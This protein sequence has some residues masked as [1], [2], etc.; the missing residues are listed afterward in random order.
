[1]EG[2]EDFQVSIANPGTTTGS[3]IVA[4]GP[5]IVVTTITDND[6]AEWTITGDANVPEGDVA[7]YAVSFNGTLQSGETATI[8][9]GIGD[10]DTN[11]ADYTNFIAA[12]NIAIVSRPEFSFDG[13]TLTYTGDGSPM[14][15]LLIDFGTV[16]DVIVEGPEDYTISIFNPGSTSGANIGVGGSV[17]VTTTIIDNDSVLWSIIGDPSVGEGNDAQYTILLGGRLQSGETATIDL[18]LADVDTNSAD[19][20]NFAAAVNAAVAV[21]SDLSFDGT[22]LTF[23]STGASMSN[24]VVDLTAIDDVLIE[25]VED[26]TVSISNSGSTTGSMVGIGGP[27]S[28]TTSIIDNDS[29]TWSLTGDPTV[30]EGASAGYTLSL[31]GILQFGETATIDLGISEVTTS[32]SD[33]TSFVAAINAAIAGRADLSFDGTTLTYVGDGMGPMTDLV[34]YLGAIDDSLV[35][36]SEDWQI[37]ISNPGSTTGSDIQTTTATSV[38]TTVIDNDVA[39][40]SIS[41]DAAVAEGAEAKYV[42]NLA[43]TL[44][45]GE[46]ATIDLNIGNVSAIAA[47][48]GNFVGSVNDA[49]ANYTGPGTLTFD[50]T[51]LTFTS[52]GNPMDDLCIEVEA[53]D[54][55]LVEG[56]EDFQVSIANPGTTTGSSIVSAIPTIVVTTI[57]DN[58]AAAWSLTGDMTV[59]EGASANYRIALS[60]TLQTGE[61]A[62]IDLTFADIDT[63]PG[64]YNNWIAT[65]NAAVAGRSDLAFDGTTLTY[66]GTGNPMIDLIISLPTVDDVLTESTEQYSISAGNAGSTTG[67]TVTGSGLATTSITDNDS[68]LW[69][70]VGSASVDEGGTAQYK[71][72]LGGVIQAGEMASIELSIQGLEATSADYS[73]FLVAVQTA[74]AGRSDLSFDP[75]TGVLTVTGTGS[76]MADICVDLSAIDDSLIEGPERFQILLSNP[77][78]AGGLSTGVD[79]I[80]SLVTTTINDTIGDGGPIEEAVWSLGVDQT[81][82][83][84]NA[85]SYVLSLS[86]VLQASET[87]TVD[88]GLTDL[89]TT[90]TDY[91][92][93]NAAVASAVAAYVGPGSVSWDGTTFAFTSDGTGAMSPLNISLGTSNDA[94]AEGT[95]DFLIS[96]DNANSMTGASTSIDAA[97]DDAVTT[98]DDTLGSGSDDAT[99]SLIGDI[100]VDEGGIASYTVSLGGALGAGEVASVEIGLGDLDTSSADYASFVAAVNFA[101]NGYNT[102]SGPGSLNWDGTTL[103][104]TAAAD[105]DVFGGITIDFAAVDDLFLEGPERYEVTLSNPGSTTG[106]SAAVDPV[107]NVVVT[108]IND[109]VGDGG[110]PEVGGQWYLTGS[111]A[112]GE[113]NT[114]SYTVGLTGNLQAG[115]VAS[116]QFALGDIETLPGDY[117][118]FGTAVANAVAA[119]NTD[120]TSTGSLAWDGLNLT[121]TSDGR[122][123]M[124]G[125]DIDLATVQDAVVEGDER[126]NLI[127]SNAG[128]TTGLSPTVSPTQ[129][130]VTTTIIDDDMADWSIVGDA[131]VSEGGTAQYT[132]M[133][134]GILQLGETS[135]IDLGVMDVDT[136]STDYASFVSA[137]NTAIAGRPDLSFDG[138]TLTYTADGNPMADL[139]IDLAAVDDTLVESDEDYVVSI[140]NPASTT[141][142]SI[143]VG[144]STSVTTTI[145]DND[146]ATWS[147]SGATNVTEGSPAQYTV[148]LAGE[149]QAGETSTIDLGLANV[150][151]TSADYANFVSSVQ[152]AIVGRSD[153]TFDGT[154]LTYT[155]NGSPMVPLTFSVDAIDDSVVEASEDFKISISNPGSTT[156]ASSLVGGS[157]E[158]T[159][160]I[161]D[162]DDAA[163]S[164][165]GSASVGEGAFAQYTVALS[166]TLQAGESATIDLGLQNLDTNSNDYANFIAAVNAAV[167]GRSDLSFDGT[168]LTYTGDGTPMAD[169][170]IDLEA[171]DDVLTEST[172]MFRVSISNPGSPT[173]S[174]VILGG[175]SSVVT[176]IVDNDVPTWSLTGDATT[177]E[178]GSAQYTL[179]LDGAL[180]L[181]QSVSVQINL[182]DIDTN[183]SDYGDLVAAINAAIVTV[184]GAVFD[185][186]T[187]TIT[188]TAITNGPMPDI[189]FDLPIESD[190]VSEPPED[191]SIGLSNPSSSSGVAPLIDAA[192]NSV[193]T[194]INGSPVLQPDSEYTNADTPFNGNVLDNDSDP[195]G[196]TL[197]VTHVDGQ[198]IGTPIVTDCG[199]V[200]MNADGS[201][202]FTPNPGFYGIDIFT[203]TVVDSAGNEE[204]TTV[205]IEVL[206]AEIGIA[207][208]ASDPVPNG[209]DW[210][211]TFTLAVQNLGNATMTNLFLLDDVESIFGNAFVTTGAPSIQNWAG[212][213]AAPTINAS[214]PG[215]TSQNILSGGSLASGESF[216]VVFTVT[217]DP[218]ANGVSQGLSN[219]AEVSGQGVN[220]DGTPM[221]G[222]NGAPL[223]V[224]DLSD[225]GTDPGGENGSDN[226]DGIPNNDVTQILIADLGIA[227]SIVG[228]PELLFSGNYVV[229]YQVLVENT[230][231]VALSNLSLLEDL[232]TQF[233]GAFVQASGLTLVA[234]PSNVA[235]SIV[236]DSN[237]DGNQNI[238]MINGSQAS[239]LALGDS[240]AIQFSVEVDPLAASGTIG[241]QI[242]GS[243]EAVDANGD[244]LLD[245][246]GNSLSAFDLS[247][248][249]SE[250]GSTN[251]G[252]PYDGGTSQDVTGFDPP[253][254]PL[255]EISG[256]V[257]LDDNNNGIFE[258]GES[259]IEGVEITLLGTDTYG[260]PV[261]VVVFTDASGRYAF[262]G[263]NAGNYRVVETQPP[264][265]SDGIDNGESQWTIGNDEFSGIVLNWGQTFA[266][267]SFGERQSGTGGFPPTFQ[268]LPPLVASPISSLLNGYLGSPTPIYSGV[269]IGSNAYPLA[270]VSGRPIGGGYS[271]DNAGGCEVP[272]EIE[273]CEPCEAL[274]AESSLLEEQ[275]QQDGD[276][277]VEEVISDDCAVV[278]SVDAICPEF[279]EPV[280]ECDVPQ[281]K[282]LDGSF[283]KRMANWLRR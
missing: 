231:T 272:V 19:Y 247:D 248:S 101:V 140:S 249:G 209:D 22:T 147:I 92:N 79:P 80:Q 176:N 184:P 260:N 41:G 245:S 100:S 65:V 236:V 57:S 89:D 268:P 271:G 32:V 119:Y 7:S 164:I 4:S 189:V 102:G 144:P 171:I 252:D 61:T 64:D 226:G 10:V 203:Y 217:I 29:A 143:V 172:E 135:L 59:A 273:P 198:P 263:L 205:E 103:T 122:G 127:L 138:T 134:D 197:T 95:E 42:V 259:G 162:N 96:L 1:V 145:S 152:A 30:N 107:L 56:S 238:E 261:N 165:S 120:P 17:S 168:T 156:G 116:V 90:S 222:S 15:D 49:I 98:I 195:D 170:V 157:V 279:C 58:D 280:Q 177:A 106:L 50:G 153:V 257:F 76:P 148:S 155:G 75:G 70:I 193:T 246:N 52:D 213:G 45:S 34:F 18:G 23:T 166:G 237:F 207:K 85:S 266:T 206:K 69:S 188:W 114:A 13:T 186:A 139:V 73:G 108:T 267:S 154:T 174:G 9:L 109:T 216:E 221:S 187:G 97:A 278:E 158:V 33:H 121:F 163:W 175:T 54:D 242:S 178:G 60:G 81:V 220:P 137:V 112:V 131:A 214:W 104:F 46:T 115:E 128:S 167:A 88:L 87:V 234:G 218:D 173:G 256:L 269:A 44:Q 282:F 37:S 72:S 113:G 71:I 215:D 3:D 5:T 192:L 241:N 265:F 124:N 94:F 274:P 118:G 129:G 159:T 84:G 160:T 185:P 105:G 53:V 228:E 20:A 211:V 24:L 6:D 39:T 276:C 91:A 130:V 141:G 275:I 210:D 196:D 111:A 161:D 253:P 258:A 123:P 202:T 191:Y 126:F 270:L 110:P 201:Y 14:T 16:N 169:L 264:Q 225:E 99:W 125:L 68:L 277:E 212:T 230:G 8:E 183:S 200:L 25:S 182:S 255:G 86:G 204:T 254:L 93:F 26:Y 51:T 62:T 190:A 239:S 21:R 227:K 208:A 82:P 150:D 117:A 240:F 281:P 47:D 55:T 235:S 219:Q 283:L 77:A 262:S 149:L 251:P 151:T 67:S 250:P 2:S 229:T 11:S 243:G 199:T 224:T 133:L 223:V 136:T 132:V 40:W 27:S 232:S 244:P 78:S 146:S 179:S 74:V 12:V 36:G 43:G 194:T 28:V 38:T 83:E 142:S 180:Q 35:E 63:N 31:A 233:G 48:Y 181:G 66:T